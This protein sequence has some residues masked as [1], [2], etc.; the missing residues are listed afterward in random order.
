MQLKLP[1]FIKSKKEVI[2]VYFTVLSSVAVLFVLMVVI[3]NMMDGLG[4]LFLLFFIFFPAV[5]IAIVILIIYHTHR[6]P[7]SLNLKKYKITNYIAMVVSLA[8]TL[9]YFFGYRFVSNI[10]SDMPKVKY[11]RILM[12]NEN[13][14]KILFVISLAYFIFTLF[15]FFIFKYNI[16]IA[17]ILS[18]WSVIIFLVFIVMIRILTPPNVSY[19]QKGYL[20][21]LK[22]KDFDACVQYKNSSI[23]NQQF[24]AITNNLDFCLN[25]VEDDNNP[26]YKRLLYE[27]LNAINMMDKYEN[28]IIEYENDII[29]KAE[30]IDACSFISNDSKRYR[31]ELKFL[32]I[33]K[34]VDCETSSYKSYKFKKECYTSLGYVLNNF[35]NRD[36]DGDGLLD[37]VEKDVW[38]TD[39]LSK[40]TDGDTFV[41]Y[42]EIINGYN[43]NGS[44]LLNL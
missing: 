7:K 31:C 24:A 3:G 5:G 8:Y 16:T 13:D 41:D 35:K 6:L 12:S 29:D 11:F 23:C 15:L 17:R 20:L 18:I 1:K 39:P 37:A 9:Y 42:A 25:L 2:K 30:N 32:N 38:K 44:G 26:L 33:N 34:P 19:T 27:C 22:N 21:S 36:T 14:W 4:G 43:P 28:D 10:L 40:D